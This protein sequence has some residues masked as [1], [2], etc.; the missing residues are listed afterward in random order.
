M[1]KFLKPV[2]YYNYNGTLHHLSEL[3]T[4]E[5]VFDSEFN[6]NEFYAPMTEDEFTIF[7]NSLKTVIKM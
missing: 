3:G 1:P 5:W 4:V 2:S 6:Y 7:E